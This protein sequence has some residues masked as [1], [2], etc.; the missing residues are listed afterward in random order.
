MNP[1]QIISILSL[2]ASSLPLTCDPLHP[3]GVVDAQ[4][5]VEDLEDVSQDEAEVFG[6]HHGAA[7][8]TWRRVLRTFLPPVGQIVA[9]HGEDHLN[10][11]Q[12][13]E[14]DETCASLQICHVGSKIL[15]LYVYLDC[16][17]H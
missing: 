16:V 5:V 10:D 1:F 15:N 12:Q 2:T 7:L 14:D 17:T 3:G 9:Q 13:M 8:G 11:L 4:V 6:G